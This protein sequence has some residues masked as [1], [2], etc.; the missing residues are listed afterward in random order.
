MG[1]GGL[2]W[3][4]RGGGLG[5]WMGGLGKWVGGGMGGSEEPLLQFS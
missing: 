1:W 3:V 2:G 4:G 5:R